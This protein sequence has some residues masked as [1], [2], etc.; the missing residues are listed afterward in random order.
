MG[1]NPSELSMVRETSARPSGAREEVPAK[2]TSDID[3]P[4]SDL[5]PC[6]PMTQASASTTF[7]LP[8]PLGPTTQVIP[9]SRCRVVADAKDLNPRSVSVFRCTRAAYPRSRA[10]CGV[11]LRG[12]AQPS[13][14]RSRPSRVPVREPCAR[15]TAHSVTG[16]GTRLW[17]SGTGL[18]RSGSPLR[19]AA[20]E[21]EGDLA[22]GRLRGVRPVDQVLDHL[23]VPRPGEVAADRAGG[24]R[25]RLRR[26]GERAE[27]LDDAVALDDRGDKRPGAHELHE[28]LEVRTAA[29]LVVVVAEERVVRGAQLQG[30]DAVTLGLDPAQDLPDEAALDAVGLDEDEGAF[31]GLRGSHGATL[32]GPRALTGHRRATT[33]GALPV[34]PLL[35]LADDAL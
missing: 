18:W 1:S 10:R 28:R 25:R 4:R 27:A 23:G 34:L 29:V 9:G 14:A 3:P 16:T 7:D 32:P 15:S 35:P 22:L 6:S 5:A 33:G 11:P 31:G 26:A 17:R 30:G 20:G 19:S 2:M 24:R 12:C 13:R 8:E 21:P